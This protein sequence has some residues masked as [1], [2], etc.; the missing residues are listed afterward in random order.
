RAFFKLIFNEKIFSAIKHDNM[1][2]KQ[3]NLPVFIHKMRFSNCFR[4]KKM[5]FQC[6]F[7]FSIAD[8]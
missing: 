2:S 4:V 6:L 5:F 8:H 1:Q 7:I 3:E